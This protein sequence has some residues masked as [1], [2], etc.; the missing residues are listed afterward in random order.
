[1]RSRNI[2]RSF[3]GEKSTHQTRSD[4]VQSNSCYFF[5]VQED[6]TDQQKSNMCHLHKT[7]YRSCEFLDTMFLVYICRERQPTALIF[8]G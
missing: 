7:L 3:S 2:M 4:Q 1:M 8:D 5:K 6:L